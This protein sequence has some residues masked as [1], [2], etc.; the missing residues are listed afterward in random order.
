MS[1]L[2]T[3]KSHRG[4]LHKTN[5]ALVVL[6]SMYIVGAAVA[7]SAPYWVSATSALAPLAAFA[8]TPLG[9]GILAT[10]SA[11]LIGLAVYSIIRNNEVSAVKAPKIIK[12]ID[13]KPVLQFKREVFKEM[14]SYK[15]KDGKGKEIEGKCWERS[16][17]GKHYRF[18]FGDK[19]D[20]ELGD[21]LLLPVVSLEVKKDGKFEK[22]EP[23]KQMA[24][25]GFK[26]NNDYQEINTHLDKLFIYEVSAAEQT[27][28]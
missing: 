23:G 20:E 17:R 5:T 9:I 8:A 22:I 1:I 10:V 19:P 24:E 13:G 6:T 11:A 12:G 21:T 18:I 26:D 16:L 25:L 15:Y 14:E 28:K 2:R 27:R 3:F 4:Q 7:L